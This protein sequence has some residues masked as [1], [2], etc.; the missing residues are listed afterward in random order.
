M[1]SSA[2]L[3]GRFVRGHAVRFVAG[4][5]V[6]LTLVLG[7]VVVYFAA[8]GAL[9]VFLHTLFVTPLRFMAEGERAGLDRLA[10]STK[11]FLGQYAPVLAVA[12][13]ATGCRLRERRDPF[14]VALSLA[15]LAS[16]AALLAQ[17]LSWWPYHF[18]LPGTLAGVLAAY[19]WPAL[20][21]T[22][23]DRLNSP[24]SAREQTAL[25]AFAGVLFLE[26]GGAGGYQFLRLAQCQMGVTADGRRTFRESTGSAYREAL[27]ETAW[28]GGSDAKAGPIFVCGD[29]LF[30]WLSAR[31]PATR[32]SGW[33][34]EIYPREIRL[35]L[36]EEVRRV[37]PVYVYVASQPHGYDTLVRE[38][39]P[40]LSHFLA[41][42][43]TPVRAT[44]SGIWYMR[45]TRSVH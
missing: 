21:G 4:I 1:I 17:R 43:Y 32:I 5:G 35:A 41:T 15:C 6:G 3:P 36:A 10:V 40:E 34:L 7:S 16:I 45:R 39:Y 27:A 11:W 22:V 30:Y 29:P 38:R 12:V 26:P 18:L 19:A 8:H 33:S 13:L 31:K 24:L 20:V 25:A 28:L 42:H 37:E 2:F 14:V 23:R 9:E 44:R